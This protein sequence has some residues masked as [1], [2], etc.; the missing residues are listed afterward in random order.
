MSDVTDL[1]FARIGGLLDGAEVKAAAPAKKKGGKV[2]PKPPWLDD[3]EDVRDRG[4]DEAEEDD[5]EDQADGGDDEATEDESDDKPP[6]RRRGQKKAL[7]ATE[8]PPASLK[9]KRQLPKQN[10]GKVRRRQTVISPR[11]HLAR[12]QHA[13]RGTNVSMRTLPAPAGFKAKSVEAGRPTVWGPQKQSVDITRVRTPGTGS[14]S[15]VNAAAGR[16]DY[17]RMAKPGTGSAGGNGVTRGR[18]DVRAANPHPGNLGGRR[19]G[20][21]VRH[22]GEMGEGGAWGRSGSA[23]I[24]SKPGNI[25]SLYDF[26]PDELQGAITAASKAIRGVLRDFEAAED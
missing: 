13:S 12:V 7:P 3:P 24:P 26:T 21:K 19:G 4:A 10:M 18:G 15:R 1:Q 25:K 2:K 8:K 23:A 6:R 22:S 5:P 9:A 14:D 11:G 17:G 20:P 16:R